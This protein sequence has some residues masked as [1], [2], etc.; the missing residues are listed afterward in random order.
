M[1]QKIQELIMYLVFTLSKVVSKTHQ[2]SRDED[3][4]A[5]HQ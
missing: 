2:R 5:P 1:N 4:L 3:I